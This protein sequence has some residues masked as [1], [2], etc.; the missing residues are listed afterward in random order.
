[1][2]V[3]E[4]FV[5][6]GFDV[7]NQKLKD[8]QTDLNN[9][10]ASMLKLGAAATGS[11]W[12]FERLTVKF[13]ENSLQLQQFNALTG[14]SIEELQKWQAAATLSN[15]LLSI[16]Q[17][18]ASVQNLSK[19][20]SDSAMGRGNAGGIFSMITG[21][22]IA[23]KSPFEVL[24]EIRKHYDDAVSRWPNGQQ[25][26]NNMIAELGIDPGMLNSLR[27][28]REEFDKLA[29]N[30]ILAQG[31][32][33][34]LSEFRKQINEIVF[35][36]QLW[37]EI[38]FSELIPGIKEGYDNIKPILLELKENIAGAID[39]FRKLPGPAQAAGFVAFLAVLNP[40]M[41]AFAFVL[42]G[43][44]FSLSEI[45]RLMTGENTKIGDLIRK[46]ADKIT[47]FFDNGIQD[48]FDPNMT[49]LERFR[50]THGEN[51][52]GTLRGRQANRDITD[53][54]NYPTEAQLD[55]LLRSS[56]GSG[57]AGAPSN[58]T[59]HNNVEIHSS[60]DPLA[61]GQ[62][63]SRVIQLNN[64]RAGAQLNNSPPY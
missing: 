16:D 49:P 1:M 4:L 53:L 17:V 9:G 3:G 43:I 44:V 28:T 37:S 5:S 45:E 59:I 57:T 8:F 58:I 13:S 22:S 33:E 2:N 21:E 19:A 42:N 18:T 47:P 41:V 11:L 38:Q 51:R 60:G 36:L 14:E 12:A 27:L 25:S 24:E 64:N 63:V 61:V 20:I 54:T 62:E 32:I 56:G 39:L 35:D 26:V 52:D 55:H 46:G 48:N 6:L 30:R 29:S 34:K 31:S 15:P 50:L 7:D 40:Q 10:L 23:G